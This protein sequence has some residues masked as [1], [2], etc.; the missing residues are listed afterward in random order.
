MASGP[1]V[2]TENP[3]SD[4]SYLVGNPRKVRIWNVN[5]QPDR[6]PLY[7]EEGLPGL[8]GEGGGT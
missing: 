1:V 5:S 6:A 8:L 2:K 7:E 3:V 4:K